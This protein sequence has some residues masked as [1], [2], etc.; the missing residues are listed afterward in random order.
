MDLWMEGNKYKDIASTLNL[1]IGTVAPDIRKTRKRIMQ[2]K[3]KYG[4]I[5]KP[6]TDA[7]EVKYKKT[8]T[9]EQI[10]IRKEKQKIYRA[11]NRDKINE[12]QKKYQQEHY[13]RKRIK[14]NL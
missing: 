11:K 4:L 13:Q 10:E 5:R 12:Y 14:K 1:P 6:K 7:N 9:S 3:D 2:E 8:L